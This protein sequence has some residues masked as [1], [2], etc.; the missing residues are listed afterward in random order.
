MLPVQILLL[1]YHELY[2][3]LVQYSTSKIDV[4]KNSGSK[5]DT[6]GI[7]LSFFHLK[8]FQRRR[9]LY[10]YVVPK[11]C[12][13]KKSVSKISMYSKQMLQIFI[14][15]GKVPQLS[16]TFQTERQNATIFQ[17][18]HCQTTPYIDC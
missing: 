2:G 3:R 10:L 11:L 18:N 4:D 1:P 8:K 16:R 9:Q 14:S 15:S 5:L 17:I 6:K 7:F 13:Q 12:S